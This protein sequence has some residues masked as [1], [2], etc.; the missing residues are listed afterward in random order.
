MRLGFPLPILGEQTL[1]GWFF[2]LRLI[3]RNIFFYIVF[4]ML[5]T[6]CGPT[7]E[8]LAATVFFE[9]TQTQAA[10]PTETHTPTATYTS[11]ATFTQTLTSTPTPTHTFTPS[12]TPTPEPE[13]VVSSERANLRTG[14]GENFSKITTH[15]KGKTLVVLGR[16]Q[17]SSW[18][19]VKYSSSKIGWIRIDLVESIQNME[20]LS[21]IESPPTPTP[22][23]HTVTI[24]NV[25]QIDT[26]E[27]NISGYGMY[28]IAPSGSISNQ[29]KG[30]QYGF[31]FC[32][33]NRNIKERYCKEYKYFKY[34]VLGPISWNVNCCSGG[35]IMGLP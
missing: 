30:G 14:P 15:N 2:K 29:V 6:S 32:F 24:Y 21:L 3:H 23:I 10:A 13:V 28:I 33:Y 17:D 27:F 7:A 26:L 9:L 16:N 8:N 35:N 31:S 20:N 11:T 5:I 25:S 19:A 4:S 18:L 12:I 1:T 34:F 22:S